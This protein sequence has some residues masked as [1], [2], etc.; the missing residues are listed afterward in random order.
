MIILKVVLAGAASTYNYTIDRTLRTRL[1]TVPSVASSHPAT[2]HI[3]SAAFYFPFS[4]Y[5]FCCLR[6]RFK[7]V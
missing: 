3:R 6:V 7:H 2:P 1:I 5:T 4:R